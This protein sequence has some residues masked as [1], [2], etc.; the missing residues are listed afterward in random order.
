MK[1]I[2]LAKPLSVLSLLCALSFFSIETFAQDKNWRP[3]T[4]AELQSVTPAVEPGAD[5][6]AIFWEVRVDDSA[7]DELALRHY[8]R[9]KLFTERGREDFARHDVAFTKGTRIKDLEARVTKPD[10][11]SAFVTKEDVLERDIVKAS[12]FKIRAKTIAF[13]GLEVGSV[14]EYRYREVV[15]NGSANMRLI[16][17]RE[18]PIREIAYYV[19]P[20][21]GTSAMAY[22]PFNSGQVKFEKDKDGFHK[23]VMKNVPAFREEPAMLPED[24]VKSWIFIY[25]TPE[26][27][28]TPDDYWQRVSRSTFEAQK[29]SLKANDEVKLAT[30]QLIAGAA[31][32]DEKLRRIYDFTKTQIKNTSYADS[33]SEEEKKQAAKNKSAGDTFKYKL[34]TAG[35]V[36]QLFG[37]MARAAGFDAR[38]AFSGNRNELFFKRDVPNMGLMLG[39]SSIAVK[40]G[41]DWHSSAPPAILSPLEC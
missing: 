5:A 26:L 15:D 37:A 25:Y 29:S 39:S 31:S 3:V 2:S 27:P 32:D 14:V 8:V 13:P 22:Y 11:T 28:K 41:T 7:V 40:T 30:T 17:Q 16:F 1:L 10:G 35:D 12:G 33:V 38:I 20:Y 34:G 6:E 36:D 18:V 4:P 9:I 23:A 21:S 19:K 24:E